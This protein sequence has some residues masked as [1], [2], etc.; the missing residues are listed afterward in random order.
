MS[1]KWEKTGRTEDSQGTTITY[2][3]EG[4]GL[5]VQSRKR[6]IPHANGIGTWT[7]TSFFVMK[8]GEDVA[9]KNS[10]ADAKRYAEKLWEKDR[11]EKA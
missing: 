5:A 10:L 4:T 1:L 7:H 6:Q 8:S 3:A 2:S 9:E 11:G